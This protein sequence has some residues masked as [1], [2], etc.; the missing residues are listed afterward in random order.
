MCAIGCDLRAV[1]G[2]ILGGL[3]A[4]L[5]VLLGVLMSVGILAPISEG[6]LAIVCVNKLPFFVGA[7][8]NGIRFALR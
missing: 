5:R 7:L 3:G 2:A 1:C 6:E 8:G 4:L